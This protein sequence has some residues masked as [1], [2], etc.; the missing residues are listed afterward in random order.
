MM[1]NYVKKHEDELAAANDPDELDA[2]LARYADVLCQLRSDDAPT[3]MRVVGFAD[4][5]ALEDFDYF[6]RHRD[7]IMASIGP[8]ELVVAS[9]DET[10]RAESDGEPRTEVTRHQGTGAITRSNGKRR[11]RR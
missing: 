8:K 2:F 3:P 5:Q 9:V 10:T 1:L 4:Q 7:E 11:R 6:N